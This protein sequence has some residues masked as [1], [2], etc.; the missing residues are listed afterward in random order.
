MT[1]ASAL[2]PAA[3]GIQLAVIQGLILSGRLVRLRHDL[4]PSLRGVTLQ[5]RLHATQH[6]Q[7]GKI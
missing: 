6:R 1:W 7:D 5:V 2:A 3:N 4:H